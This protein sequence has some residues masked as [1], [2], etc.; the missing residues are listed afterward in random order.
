LFGGV[1]IRWFC[2]D[3]VADGKTPTEENFRFPNGLMDFLHAE[4]ADRGTLTAAPFAGQ[5]NLPDKAGKVEFAVA[6]TEDGEGFTH[7][8]CNTIPTPQGGTH[9]Q[10]LRTALARGLRAYGEMT[11]NKK[12][13]QITAD[14]VMDGAAV[15]LS[16]FIRDPQ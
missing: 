2:E 14:D 16:V 4:L 9:E 7:S 12:A 8:Y 5:A 3:K 13:S 6:W 1:E 10:G 11:G 15:L